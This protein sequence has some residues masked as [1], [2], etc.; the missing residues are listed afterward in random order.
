MSE[1]PAPSGRGRGSSHRNKGGRSGRGG[2]NKGNAQSTDGA[3]DSIQNLSLSENS[4]PK[5]GRGGN[6]GKGDRRKRSNVS[7]DKALSGEEKI[8]HEEELQLKQQVAEAE[9]IR[10]QEMEDEEAV[11]KLLEEEQKRNEA[12]KLA[13]QNECQ[14]IIKKV[15]DNIAALESFVATTLSHKRNRDNLSAE[16]L[17]KSRGDFEQAKKIYQERFEEVHCICQESQVWSSVV[18]ET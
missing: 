13:R 7:K 4:Q 2:G 18:H 17:V 1:Q 8:R 6:R 5:G 15:Q 11:R 3:T 14:A 16:N 10:R 9:A 12:I